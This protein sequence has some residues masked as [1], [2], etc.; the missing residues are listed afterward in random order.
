MLPYHH[1][2][3]QALTQLSG[4]RFKAIWFSH[5]RELRQSLGAGG[6]ALG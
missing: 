4:T 3:A 1:Q 2:R 6:G 5:F